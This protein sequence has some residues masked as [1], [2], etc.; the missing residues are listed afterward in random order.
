MSAPISPTH[1]G[2][3]GPAVAGLRTGRGAL[4]LAS[5]AALVSIVPIAYAHRE[6][7]RTLISAHG[8]LHAAIAQRFAA[9]SVWPGRPENPFFAGEPLPYYWFFHYVGARLAGLMEI[10]PLHAFE[11][12]IFLALGVLWWT[13][14]LLGRRLYGGI[15]AGLA[16]GL[17]ALAG[18]NPFGAAILLAKIGAR[19]PA[20]L[21]DRGDHFWGLL[22]PIF[23]AARLSDPFGLYGPLLNFY[24]NIS[25]R[26]VALSLLLVM[27]CCLLAWL[28]SGDRRAW[29]GLM[30]GT[31]VCTAFS[32]LIG[33]VSV[34]A[35]SGG[36][37]VAAAWTT[38]M[39]ARDANADGHYGRTLKAIAALVLGALIALPTYYYFFLG[40][41]DQS[42]RLNV[43]FWVVQGIASSAFLLVALVCVG[44]RRATG[45]HR[46][47]LLATMCAGFALLAGSAVIE[48]PASNDCN[49]FH[50]AV[51]LLAIPAAGGLLAVADGVKP[52][53][54]LAWAAV[55]LIFL[56][57]PGLV[58]YAYLHRPP[59]PLE[60]T[61]QGLV[62]V[63]PD[64]SMAH[65]Y[66][67]IR[68]R[69]APD[70]IFILDPRSLATP[71]GSIPE[72][73]ALTE[74]F[75]FTGA[76]K[77]YMVAPHGDAQLRYDI[78][79]RLLGSAPADEE[80]HAY[81]KRLGRPLYLVLSNAV[82]Y[83]DARALEGRYGSAVFRHGDVV[84][85]ALP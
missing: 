45:I 82:A 24:F 84:V 13:A 57:T 70:A 69:T 25:S 36:L 4:L 26:P 76:R 72:F 50:A 10:H 7:L 8:L 38:F 77:D 1:R 32:F 68:T 71:G 44:V 37:L 43:R 15:A 73:P 61:G 34:L 48:L 17:L 33:V 22:H 81:L 85:F 39:A 47:F 28:Q 2:G 12:L 65:L 3:G 58:A 83:H 16:I 46:Q 78:A 51:F 29:L 80:Q 67:W 6:S 54:G 66:D 40:G 60:I 27:S 31:A 53:S 42:V 5:V 79:L 63:P 52:W 64:S 59:I 75:L 9:V 41:N 21:E 14:A 20:F 19:G 56:P 23:G 55:M 30:A 35:L 62:R 49:L 18:T 11:L 74:R